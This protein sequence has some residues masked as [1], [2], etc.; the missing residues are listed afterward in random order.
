MCLHRNKYFVYFFYTLLCFDVL[1]NL[2]GRGE[3]SPP[4]TSQFLETAKD[5]ARHMHLLCRLTNPEPPLLYLPVHSRGRDSSASIIPEPGSEQPE[6][7][8]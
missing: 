8:L 5:S 1:K 6:T 7:T 4:G 2:S 3:N